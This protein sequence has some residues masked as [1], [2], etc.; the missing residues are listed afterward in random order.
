VV[1]SVSIIANRIITLH[2]VAEQAS[3]AAEQAAPGLGSLLRADR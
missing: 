2:G 1:S 3:S